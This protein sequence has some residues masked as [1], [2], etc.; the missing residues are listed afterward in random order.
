M[1]FKMVCQIKKEREMENQYQMYGEDDFE[2]YDGKTYPGRQYIK[3]NIFYSEYYDEGWVDAHDRENWT[4][5]LMCET[6]E[7]TQEDISK[8][9][10]I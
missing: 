8:L 9:L 7:T 1:K 10:D 4:R 3:N 2:G 5:E 6:F